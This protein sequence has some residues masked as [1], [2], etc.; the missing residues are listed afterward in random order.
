MAIN[1][2][3]YD[4]CFYIF[5]YPLILR[6]MPE[7]YRK[8]HVLKNLFLALAQEALYYVLYWQNLVS[9]D[10]CTPLQE[11]RCLLTTSIDTCIWYMG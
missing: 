10:T 8:L 4:V 3:Q 2:K 9:P 5:V 1:D 6:Y 7:I 11:R